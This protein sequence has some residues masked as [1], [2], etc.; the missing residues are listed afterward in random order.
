M[1]LADGT[2]RHIPHYEIMFNWM[3]EERITEIIAL[4]GRP[5]LGS[6]LLENCS[7]LLEMQDGGQVEIDR[8]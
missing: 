7:V 8:L 2:M 4:E 3:E 6:L 1:R 5:L